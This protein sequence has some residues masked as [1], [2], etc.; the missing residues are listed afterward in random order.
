M[1]F[2]SSN[3]KISSAAAHILAKFLERF[4]TRRY[5]TENRLTDFSTSPMFARFDQV[6]GGKVC[7]AIIRE[8]TSGMIPP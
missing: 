8:L 5:M 3:L 2:I 6:S 7:A 4:W 1:H